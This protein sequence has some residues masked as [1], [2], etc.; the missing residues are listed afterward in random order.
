[1][2]LTKLELQEI[3]DNLKIPVNEGVQSDKNTNASVRIV[4]WD[5]LW[6]PISASGEE[7]NTNVTY[8]ISFFSIIPRHEKLLELRKELRKKGIRPV[9]QHEYDIETKRYHSFFPIE[10]LENIEE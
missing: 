8:Q 4:Y 10:V 2:N 3:L 7:Y 6:E 1:M 5:Y 9:I